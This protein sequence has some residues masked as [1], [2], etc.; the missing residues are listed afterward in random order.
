MYPAS[1]ILPQGYNNDNNKRNLKVFLSDFNDYVLPLCKP[2]RM[3]MIKTVDE[4]AILPYTMQYHDAALIASAINRFI[5][6]LIING[7]FMR[8]LYRAFS[9][10]VINNDMQLNPKHFD[11]KDLD[12]HL[13]SNFEID[14]P[15]LIKE[16]YRTYFLINAI[17]NVLD[18]FNCKI[19]GMNVR[20]TELL[21]KFKG[22]K[23]ITLYNLNIQVGNKK[24]IYQIKKKNNEDDDDDDYMYESTKSIINTQIIFHQKGKFSD[25]V[26]NQI[27][28]AKNDFDDYINV[29]K[30]ILGLKE[31]CFDHLQKFINL[32]KKKVHNTIKQYNPEFPDIMINKIFSYLNFDSRK[33]E[34]NEKHLNCF[35]LNKHALSRCKSIS[36][37]T[38]DDVFA[39]LAKNS[40][41]FIGDC[42]ETG[43]IPI[44]ENILEMKDMF[45]E[46][47]W[48]EL[49]SNPSDYNALLYRICKLEKRNIKL[50]NKCLVNNT[51]CLWYKNNKF[52]KFEN[53]Y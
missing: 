34:L 14:V 29:K 4:E 15:A 33:K 16:E 38:I 19:N 32:W 25:F 1:Q 43:C 28:L 26:C 51:N 5:P 48:D 2:L 10:I 7:G 8:E 41:Y 37:M 21:T 31:Q 12:I 23:D 49:W 52:L 36:L 47:K 9:S 30:P 53:L 35:Y 11:L 50:L 13:D 20:E 45:L 40:T 44:D 3:L 27:C 46:N 6:G 22:Y 18:T 17:K 39:Q 42:C 24:S